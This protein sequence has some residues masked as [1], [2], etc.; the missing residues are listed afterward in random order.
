MVRCL[1]RN[2][3][4]KSYRFEL[5]CKTRESLFQRTENLRLGKALFQTLKLLG[6]L[7]Q[8]T[9]K[10]GLRELFQTAFLDAESVSNE[11]SAVEVE[12]LDLALSGFCEGDKPSVGFL[13]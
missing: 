9:A 7:R 1:R 12:P 4:P 3:L 10:L 13:A 2:P 11:G 6:D 5:S 8:L